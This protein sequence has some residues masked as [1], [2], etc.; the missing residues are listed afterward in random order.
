MTLVFAWV[1]GCASEQA[2]H[3]VDEGGDD[4][5][6]PDVEDPVGE[7]DP[8]DPP[9]LPGAGE[10]PLPPGT[11]PPAPDDVPEDAPQPPEHG[12]DWEHGKDALDH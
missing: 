4:A 6:A 7:V 3:K 11:V 8:A 12:H 2:I 5:D 10:D 9:T 1:L